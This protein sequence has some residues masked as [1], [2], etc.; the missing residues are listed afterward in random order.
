MAHEKLRGAFKNLSRLHRL[1]ERI[2]QGVEH[3][4]VF[5][6]IQRVCVVTER[7]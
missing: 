5:T 2:T 7:L 4:S 3:L 6:Q 1:S